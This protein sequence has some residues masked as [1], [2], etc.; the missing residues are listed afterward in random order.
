M[1]EWVLMNKEVAAFVAGLIVGF[2]VAACMT[3]IF[4]R[5]FHDRLGFVVL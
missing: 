1:Q 2:E 5:R 4:L 3:L